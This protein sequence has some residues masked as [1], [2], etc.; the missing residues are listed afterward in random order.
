[1]T[2]LLRRRPR[3]LARRLSW[4]AIASLAAMAL[5][6][7]PGIALGQ[8]P[9]IATVEPQ[10]LLGDNWRL[11]VL[12]VVGAVAVTLRRTGAPIKRSNQHTDN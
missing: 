7:T 9:S 10:S 4:F 3:G 1:M 6:A 12:A 2:T 11:I 8:M 5:F